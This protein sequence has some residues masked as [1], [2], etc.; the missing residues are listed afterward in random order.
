ML[1]FAALI[2]GVATLAALTASGPFQ[3]PDPDTIYFLLNIDIV[4]FLL[5]SVMIIRRILI[6]WRT[7]KQRSAATK[8]Q[9]R[10]IR[11]FSALAILPSVLM[12]IFSLAFFYFAIQTWFSE[13]V[14]LAVNESLEVA[15]A[16][17]KEHQ[18]VIRADILAMANDLNRD[19]L[20]LIGNP[21]LLKKV[22]ERQSFIRNL[23]EAMVFEEDGRVLAKSGLT[24]S[25]EFDSIPIQNLIR[26]RT[27]DIVMMTGENDDRIRALIY[28]ENFGGTYLFVGRMVDSDVLEHMETAQRAVRDYTALEI[29]KDDF[30]LSITVIFLFVALI[31]VLAAIL[32]GLIF[33]RK[34]V[35]PVTELIKATERVR[36][37]DFHVQ[38]KERHDKDNDEIDLLVNAFNK[39]T[40]QINNH[41]N[42][43]LEANKLLEKRRH[44]IEAV[45]S[46]VR[47]TIIGINNDRVITI[48]NNSALEL[49]GHGKNLIGQQILDVHA[50]L[51]A[52]IDRA[53]ES[54]K[55]VYQE[56]IN[57]NIASKNANLL[58]RVAM[59]SDDEEEL[60]VITLD[61][62]S[63]LVAAQRKAAWSGVARRIA[64]EI[65]NPLTPIRLS[66]ERMERKFANDIEKDAD[67]FTQCTQTIIRQVDT[68]GRMVN[69]FSEFARMPEPMVKEINLN[70]VLE[71]CIHLIE[72][73][74][75]K[76][77]IN[78]KTIKRAN[79]VLVDKD[80][81]GQALYN[82]LKNASEAIEGAGNKKPVIDIKI[83]FKERKF[84]T[85]E[86]QDNGP[87]FDE[88]L[89]D[90][91][92]EPY[93][94]T[95]E[96]G[97]G[98]GL[99]ITKK[100]MEDHGG[101]LTIF[102]RIRN[103]CVIGATVVL[104]LPQ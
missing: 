69:E 13:K 1:V 10:L 102:N 39:M 104:S 92:T 4:I 45:F 67:V 5:L 12:A 52:L 84:L 15:E 94:T 98:L 24:F 79:K 95:K 99:A 3:D 16:Y 64:H 17:L 51:D 90:Q 80:M 83:S 40:R 33:A 32:F 82:I 35:E 66:A 72:Q 26:A 73:S 49:L 7:R 53:I 61:D 74:N 21:Q 56:N 30:E 100:I 70:E 2:A 97:T 23:S 58:I 89:I 19:S 9:L 42:D 68:I 65:K 50:E 18:K 85:I 91:I 11:I 8:L 34:I 55:R 41:Q 77:K 59:E 101:E 60:A 6:L 28:L 25:L 62:V 38:L 75:P 36:G 47:T 37:G 31:V 22:I 54:G 48:C 46:G 93:M 86:I 76:L 71:S 57:L 81:I 43:L 103:N 14:S 20:S 87:G 29:R 44:F 78:L 63:E 88:T 27:G 96:K